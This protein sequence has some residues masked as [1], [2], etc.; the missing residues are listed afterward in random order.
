MSESILFVGVFI[1]GFL[2][3]KKGALEN[4]KILLDIQKRYGFKINYNRFLL[5]HEGQYR[6]IKLLFKYFKKPKAVFFVYSASSMGYIKAFKEFNVPVIEIQ[7]GVINKEHNAY[8]VN[9]D[10]GKTLFPDYILTYGNREL[11]VFNNP[12]NYFIK[13]GNARPVGYYLLD[14][15]LTS[16]F[17]DQTTYIQKYKKNYKKIVAYTH[18]EIYE[19]EILD[20]LIEAANL[21]PKV[22]FLLLPRFDLKDQRDNLPEN[23]IVEKNLNVYDCLRFVD[24]HATIFSTCAL[25]SLSFGVPNIMY[26][27]QNL[28]KSYYADI[29][30]D[31]LHTVFIKSPYE[32][33]H[34]IL[35]HSFALK[36]YI[37]A[38]SDKFFKR[39]FLQNINDFIE[40]ELN[41]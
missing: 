38:A 32:F 9:N 17:D 6:L 23:L 37:T 15:Y 24:I 7:H 33:V 18:Q 2:G 21:A 31:E 5:I 10:F 41:S 39:N 36:D 40:E 14:R 3:F 29:L 19:K 22:L 25:E 35:N 28:A 1:L 34:V 26:N 8:N 4:E 13:P 27:Y 20:F 16:A 12:E 30:G 11:D